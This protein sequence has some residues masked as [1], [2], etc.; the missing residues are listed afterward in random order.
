[1]H[2]T[3]SYCQKKTLNIEIYQSIPTI[4]KLSNTTLESL[5]KPLQLWTFCQDSR[6]QRCFKELV[7]ITGK[8]IAKFKKEVEES[9]NCK[10][11]G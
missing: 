7:T 8:I 9:K 3:P 4:E 2:G 1:M 10:Q 5:R 11:I 6:K